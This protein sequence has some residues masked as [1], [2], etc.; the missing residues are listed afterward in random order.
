MNCVPSTLDLK[1]LSGISTFEI[2]FAYFFKSRKN[3]SI[4][5]AVLCESQGET[6]ICSLVLVRTTVISDLFW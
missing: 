3:W 5:G 6:N 4:V 2:A 1:W